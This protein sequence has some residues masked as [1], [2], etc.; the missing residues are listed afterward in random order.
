MNEFCMIYYINIIK[1]NLEEKNI[2]KKL[3]PTM[4]RLYKISLV[5]LMIINFSVALA[6]TTEEIE[7]LKTQIH[8]IKSFDPNY[9]NDE[10]LK[11]LSNYIGDSEVVALGEV[12]HGSSE[13]FKMK[14]RIIKYLANHNDFDIF[15]IEAN[16][17]EAYKLNDYIIDKKDIDPKTLLKGMYFWIWQT[18]EV[19]DM[20]NWMKEYGEIQ[21]TGFDMQYYQG[22]LNEISTE[23]KENKII[24][25]EITKISIVLNNLQ[26][27]RFKQNIFDKLNRKQTKI[28]LNSINSILT[29]INNSK[30]EKTKKIWLIQNCRIIQQNI[31]NF[32]MD[33]D[34]YM[35]DNLLW[36]INK[37]PESKIIVWAHNYHVKKAD[38]TMGYYLEKSLGTNY[39][40]VGFAF[41]EGRYTA[42]GENGLTTCKAEKT[43]INSY[44]HFFNSI[45]ESIFFIDLRN[46]KKQNSKYKKTL[47]KSLKFRDIGAVKPINEFV[48]INLVKNYDIIIYIKKTTPSKLF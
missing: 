4:D 30:L 40:S 3:A 11:I 36:I 31:T 8:P 37:N 14:H 47:L 5:F 48:K 33:R 32:Y 2:I 45:N 10:D 9:N 25:N 6:Q 17:P 29:S 12:T 35:A 19:L 44:E 27:R 41:F 28:I 15:S 43:I 16:M 23:F 13:I 38:R 39:V 18:Q 1:I 26:I 21:F 42:E 46:V 20:V 22:A 7:W 34:K 24:Q